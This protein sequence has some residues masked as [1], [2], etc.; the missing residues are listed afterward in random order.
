MVGML[1]LCAATPAHAA[2]TTVYTLP[3]SNGTGYLGGS[4]ASPPIGPVLNAS[5]NVVTPA[6]EY[7]SGG[8]GPVEFNTTGATPLAVTSANPNLRYIA[9]PQA[10]SDSNY[11]GGTAFVYDYSS[12]QKVY[13]GSEAVRW[14]P[15]GNFSVLGSLGSDANGLTSSSVYSVNNAGT[16]IGNTEKYDSSHNSLGDRAVEWTA[17]SAAP[18]ELQTLGVGPNG[19]TNS[20]GYA[21][22]NSGIAV[23]VSADY[24]QSSSGINWAVRWDAAGNVTKLDTL[25]ATTGGSSA[26]AINNASQVAG[27]L[28]TNAVR[29]GASGNAQILHSPWAQASFAVTHAINEISATT[30]TT[31]MIIGGH[32]YGDRG[33][34][35]DATGTPT[36]LAVLSTDLTGRG[37]SQSWALNDADSAVGHSGIYGASGNFL[38]THAVWWSPDGTVHDLN[39][40]ISPASGWVLTDAYAINDAGWITGTGTFDPDGPGGMA[41]ESSVFLMQVPAAAVPEPAGFVLAAAGAGGLLWQIRRQRAAHAIE[42]PAS[43]GNPAAARDPGLTLGPHRLASGTPKLAI[44]SGALILET[45]VK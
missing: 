16:I 30:G 35:W 39:S 11:V 8:L 31:E 34:T 36:A 7:P 33:V 43:G 44:R 22:N 38:G 40:L 45:P 24:L 42:R 15:Q 19:Q 10:V 27:S 18:L 20:S 3:Y 25:G 9:E 21:I 4:L 1:L 12:G 26:I 6:Y 41:P 28:G 37:E 14:D 2:Y 29:W 13:A 17:G 5:G 32:D 23:G